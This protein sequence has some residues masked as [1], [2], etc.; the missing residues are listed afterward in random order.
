MGVKFFRWHKSKAYIEQPQLLIL[1][2]V[3][4]FDAKFLEFYVFFQLIK[5]QQYEGFLPDTQF[6]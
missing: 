4:D 1:V 6:K 3:I 2:V 5:P